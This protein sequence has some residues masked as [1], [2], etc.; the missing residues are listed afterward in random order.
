M[1]FSVGVGVLEVLVAGV[2]ASVW[3]AAFVAALAGWTKVPGW[4]HGGSVVLVI[5][6]T[7]TYGLGVVIDGAADGLFTAMLQYGYE[8]HRSPCRNGKFRKDESEKWK[9]ARSWSKKV[10]IAASIAL[11][12][13]RK[14][15]DTSRLPLQADT[16]RQL[17]EKALGRDNGLGRFMEYQRARQRIAR[18]TALNLILL[19]PFGLWFLNASQH[20][21][22]GVL[23]GFAVA[24]LVGAVAS[25]RTAERLRRRYEEH[26]VSA[27]GPD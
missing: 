22:G 6:A 20:V 24:V 7:L 5:Y 21:S 16:F 12:R 23:A 18:S 17:R 2:G 1:P 10:A 8:Y 19:L 27:N 14:H 4:A 3:V 13:N 26:L 9:K 11:G 15:E 25:G